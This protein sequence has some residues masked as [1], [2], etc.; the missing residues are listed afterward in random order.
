MK[1]DPHLPPPEVCDWLLSQ[2]WST[3]IPETS[4]SYSPI[5]PYG[6]NGSRLFD[7]QYLNVSIGA[8]GTAR[9]FMHTD[10]MQILQEDAEARQAGLGT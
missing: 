5:G 7:Y 4:I 8:D 2:Q 9:I 10:D 1:R 6:S 3:P